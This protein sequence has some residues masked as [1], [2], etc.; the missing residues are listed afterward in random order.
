MFDRDLISKVQNSQLIHRGL[1]MKAH[2][3]EAW[4]DVGILR[5]HLAYPSYKKA[6]RSRKLNRKKANRPINFF[7]KIDIHGQF[8]MTIQS[9]RESL[10]L[11]LKVKDPQGSQ[12]L[13]KSHPTHFSVGY[14]FRSSAGII[15]SYPHW[16]ADSIFML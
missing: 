11:S 6:R 4:Q 14:N 7:K 10:L 9:K 15:G 1:A 8:C 2:E 16:K 5:D 3:R 12:Y 13:S